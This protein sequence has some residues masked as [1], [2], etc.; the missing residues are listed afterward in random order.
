MQP[1][2]EN[3]LQSATLQ[4]LSKT[5]ARLSKKAG[6]DPQVASDQRGHGVG[7]S[8]EVYT[9]DL[10]QKRAALRQLEAAALGP[11]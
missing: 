2:L 3:A 9:P 7:V 1:K 6:V 4:V 10:E 11:M 5:N 8:L